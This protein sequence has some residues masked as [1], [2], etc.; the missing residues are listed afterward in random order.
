MFK[1]HG[2]VPGKDLAGVNA[3]GIEEKL[4]TLEKEQSDMRKLLLAL[5]TTFGKVCELWVLDKKNLVRKNS[6]LLDDLGSAGRELRLLGEEVEG[7]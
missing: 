2:V 1:V 7:R 5:A 6:K 4:R 3:A